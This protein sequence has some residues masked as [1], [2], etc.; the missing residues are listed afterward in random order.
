MTDLTTRSVP[1]RLLLLLS[2]AFVA[3]SP[4]ESQGQSLPSTWNLRN[5]GSPNVRGRAAY[6]SGRFDV[7]GAGADIWGTADEGSFV[8]RRLSGDMSVVA[9]VADVEHTHRWA[10][11]GVMI[12]ESLAAGSKHA[13]MLVSAARGVAFQ[14][15]RTT[16]SVT[17]NTA[18][19]SGQAPTWV[20][21]IRRAS[22]FTA[23]RSSDGVSWKKVGAATI[24]M[25]SAVYVGLAVTSH[26]VAR[27]ATV[28]FSKVK[29]SRGAPGGPPAGNIPPTVSLSSP[30]QGALFSPPASIAVSAA[31]ADADGSVAK[32][33]FY[34]GKTLIGSDTTSPYRVS[35]PN[36][37][38]GAYTLIA[39]AT[40]NAGAS[41]RSAARVVVVTPPAATLPTKAV[42]VPS[43]DHNT[44]RVTS[45]RLEVFTLG[46][47]PGS[48]PVIAVQNLGKPG[49]VSGACVAN[50]AGTING[51][52]SGV[53]IATVRAVGPGGMSPRAISAAFRR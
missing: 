40:D 48:S 51:L 17:L 20:K 12:R 53:Y 29:I 7:E 38:A 6:A 30:A 28:K 23:Y 42:F 44:R 27:R 35:W 21:L 46:S 52:P 11:G 16:D 37:P 19:G 13:Y 32:V 8:Y 34:S 26:D 22:T 25:S 39:V 43:P 14:R 10:K 9:R 24:P 45:Y 5:L 2:V 15:R 50:I 47:N 4:V 3:A 36:V 33:D 1:A 18:G 41:A 49:V 31:A